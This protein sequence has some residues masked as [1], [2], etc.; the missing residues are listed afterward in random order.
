MVSQ[1]AWDDRCILEPCPIDKG[2][3]Y[4]RLRLASATPDQPDP[5]R[6]PSSSDWSSDSA[7]GATSDPGNE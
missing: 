2:A 3:L 4:E 1:H 7:A 5:K 6:P